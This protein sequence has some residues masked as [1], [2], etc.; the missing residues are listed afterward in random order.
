MGHCIWVE[1]ERSCFGAK[2]SSLIGES[3]DAV[4]DGNRERGFTKIG[5]MRG[6]ET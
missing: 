5:G 1:P 4:G 2:M 6:A 3:R